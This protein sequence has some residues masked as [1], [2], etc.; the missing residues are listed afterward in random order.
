MGP[1]AVLITGEESTIRN[2]IFA[3]ARAEFPVT[4][5]ELVFSVKRLIKELNRPNPFK[6]NCPGKSW[7]KGF[8][9]RNP[10]I[11]VRTSQNLTRSRAILSKKSLLNWFKQVEAF[12]L[13]S[14][15]KSILQDPRRIFN[16]DETVFF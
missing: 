6:D 16:T 2:W 8:M 14:E 3:M 11:A 1:A 4:M 12:L 5:K 13:E 15:Q 9:R 7:M 10:G